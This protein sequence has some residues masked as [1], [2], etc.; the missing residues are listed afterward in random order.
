MS[1][2]SEHPAAMSTKGFEQASFD[3]MNTFL[4]ACQSMSTYNKTPPASWQDIF[5]MEHIYK[6][7]VGELT[8]SPTKLIHAQKD[9]FDEYLE[10]CQQMQSLLQG[11]EVIKTIAPEKGDKRFKSADWHEKPYFFYLQQSYLLLVQHCN[12]FVEENKSD[13]PKIAKQVSFFTKQFLNAI[14][15][16]NF[17]YGNPE[18]IKQIFETKGD[19]LFQGYKHFLN[20]VIEGKGHFNIKMTDTS[21]FEIGKNIATTPGKVIFQNRMLQLIQYEATTEKVHKRPLLMIPPWINKYYIL[22]IREKNSLVKWIVEQGFTVFMISWVNPDGSYQETTFDDYLI[23]GLLEAISA[24]EKATGEKEINALGFCIGGTLLS[25]CLAYMKAKKDKR[26]KSATFLTTL[27]DFTDP[28]EIEVFIDDCQLNSLEQKMENDGYLDGR[29]L[30]T[31]FNMLRVNDLI[32]PY[33]INNY[34]CGQSPFP[35]DLLYWNCDSVNLPKKML[36]FYLRNLYLNNLLIEKDALALGGVKLDLSKIDIPAYFLSTEQDHIAPWE[37]TFMGAKLFSGPTTFVLGGSGHIAGVVNP[38]SSHKYSFRFSDKNVEHFSDPK[39]WLG[40]SLQGE[41][42]WWTHWIKWLEQYSGEM[43]KARVPGSG[44]L[45]IL[46]DAP[47][48]YVTKRLL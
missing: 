32:W 5:N 35:F 1:H 45:P 19:S 26:I 7:W 12:K 28:G 17:I 30:M 11:K 39:S 9:F 20:D 15:P 33:Y 22:D 14:A 38:P 37:S 34:L 16:S 42:S 40:A 44:K 36:S 43:L 13:N 24:V 2:K 21:A 29:V 48:E 31:T 10:L 3:L 8:R 27:I 41:G 46:Q 18:V 4:N 47:G 6:V 25:C 23:D